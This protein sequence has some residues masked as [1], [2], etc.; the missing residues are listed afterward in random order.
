[1]QPPF[2]LVTFV[3]LICFVLLG[4]CPLPSSIL[5]PHPP[6]LL[7][8]FIF[9]LVPRLCLSL[10]VVL[11]LCLSDIFPLPP[12]LATPSLLYSDKTVASSLFSC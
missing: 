4:G 3:C 6:H 8:L 2:I 11:C 10:P 12:S 5:K 7:F 9:I 1:M